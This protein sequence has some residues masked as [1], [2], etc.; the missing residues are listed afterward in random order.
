LLKDFANVDRIEFLRIII[1]E[2][3]FIEKLI[4]IGV[5]NN[6]SLRHFWRGKVSKNAPG[7]VQKP[8]HMRTP[9]KALI[10]EVPSDLVY[11][12]SRVDIAFPP[13]KRP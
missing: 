11:G 6:S 7:R 4:F 9:V 1:R 5:L 2:C 12:I 10:R 8:S 3:L 13:S